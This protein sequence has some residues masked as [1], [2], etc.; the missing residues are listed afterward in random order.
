MVFKALVIS[1]AMLTMA[2]LL[3]LYFRKV[4]GS[5]F[6]EAVLAAACW[7]ALNWALDIVALLPFTHQTSTQYFCE[8]GIE[9]P[10][11]AAIVIAAGFLMEL[12]SRP[13]TGHALGINS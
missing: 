4:T 11:S 5:Y 3:A 13:E 12:K 6:R 10:S 1:V 8:I 9:Y 2:A 7:V